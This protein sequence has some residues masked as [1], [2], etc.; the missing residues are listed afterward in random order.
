MDLRCKVF[1][2]NEAGELEVAVN[3]F[4]SEDLSQT[5]P[6]QFEEITQ[7]EGPGGITV[8]VWYSVIDADILLDD[9]GADERNDLDDHEVSNEVNGKELA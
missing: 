2:A 8:L 5:G 6:V 3:R 4:L 9:E 1:R 7:S